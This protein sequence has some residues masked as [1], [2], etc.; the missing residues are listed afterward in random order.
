MFKVKGKTEQGLKQTDLV[1]EYTKQGAKL[2]PR[3][4]TRIRLLTI[5]DIPEDKQKV[6]YCDSELCYIVDGQPAEYLS[7]LFKTIVP[8]RWSL[9]TNKL[10]YLLEIS[11]DSEGN[12][13]AHVK[14]NG[15]KRPRRS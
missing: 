13:V 14:F 15:Q 7:G 5:K 1:G 12:E 2:F 6:S 11:T 8:N 10:K 9:D 4:N 3:F